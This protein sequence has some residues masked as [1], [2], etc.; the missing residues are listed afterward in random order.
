MP[1]V[2]WDARAEVHL[3]TD[4]R[5]YLASN[6]APADSAIAGDLQT[7]ADRLAADGE[8][9]LRAVNARRLEVVR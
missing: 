9:R 1:A 7:W 6:A 3:A 4:I 2:E 5:T 8:L